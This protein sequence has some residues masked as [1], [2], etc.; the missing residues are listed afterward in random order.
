MN[1]ASL[2][3]WYISF[4]SWQMFPRR[5]TVW[6]DCLG[7]RG[8]YRRLLKMGS[9]SRKPDRT[10]A[11]YFVRYVGVLYTIVELLLVLLP[12]RATRFTIATMINREKDNRSTHN[13]LQS[14]CRANL[15]KRVNLYTTG[16]V[17][18]N[19]EKLKGIHSWSGTSTDLL[20]MAVGLKSNEYQSM[21]FTKK[22]FR[23]R[24]FDVV[25]WSTTRHQSDRVTKDSKEGQSIQAS[26]RNRKDNCCHQF[27]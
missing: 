19:T 6:F 9:T 16:K 27:I 20:C 26:F 1:D 12:Q 2:P 17:L 10:A 11:I 13:K 14:Y 5:N 24:L 22:P 8:G 15:T 7:G 25:I 18:L 21:L 4:H 23:S 3:F